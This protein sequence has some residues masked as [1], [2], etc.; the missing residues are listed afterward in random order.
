MILDTYKF[1]QEH[2]W[3]KIDNEVA[4][5]G[6]TEYATNE[7]GEIVY[8]ELPE[9]NATIRQTEEFGSVESVK[10]VSSLYSPISGTVVE[11][12]EQ[13]AENPE[14]INESN[15]ENGWIIKIKVDDT[16]EIDELL[17]N[18]E[19]TNHIEILNEDD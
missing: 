7:L 16:S 17:T 19:Y 9:V 15:Y 2:E 8:V 14:L 11:V 12:N 1:T 4:T 5:I 13:L 10:S 3:L 6:I 18:E